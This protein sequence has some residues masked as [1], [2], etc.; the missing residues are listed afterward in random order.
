MAHT[1]SN[2]PD[3]PRRSFL[4]AHQHMFVTYAH[5]YVYLGQL[6]SMWLH[7]HFEANFGDFLE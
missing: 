3:F 4:F 5:P 1:V 2:F 6:I 7:I